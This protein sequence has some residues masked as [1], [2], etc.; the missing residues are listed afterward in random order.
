MNKK[1]NDAEAESRLHSAPSRRDFLTQAGLLAGGMALL[2]IPGF[3]TMAQ[4]V[5][6]ARAYSSG[7]VALELDGQFV[8]FLKSADGGFAK[9]EVVTTP[10]GSTSPFPLKHLASIKYQDIVI[11][12]DPVM[13][14]PFFDWI[15]AELNG[16]HVRKNGAIIT[17]DF[18]RVERSRLQFNHALITEIGLPACDAAS[19]DAGLLTVKFAPE[20]T[21]PLAGKGGN[22]V[23]AVASKQQ[24][25]WIQ[26]NFRLRIQGL[27]DACKS[28][29]KIEA[30]VFKQIIVQDQVGATRDY[31]K[32]PAKMEFPNLVLFLSESQ[33]GPF[34][35]WFEDFVV[36]G[37]N[38]QD[39]ERPGVLELLAPDLKEVLLTVNF[40]N[41]GIFGFTPDKQM[42]GGDAIRRVKVE[43]YCERLTLAQGGIVSTQPPPPPL[44]MAPP[45]GQLAPAPGLTLPGGFTPK[46]MPR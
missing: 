3:R 32:E 39:R 36:K 10:I 45:P 14:K 30:L 8:D 44:P 16:S 29:S 24:K 25:P 27:E 33:A 18:N 15:A 17:A 5:V 9:G 1:Q 11:Q 23:G 41:L 46:V 21:T 12:C 42:V 31:Q 28:A 37:N 35:A 22:V 2:S 7:N 4:A 26:N 6:D 40:S 20:F 34:Y 38:G 19:K 13:P 43:M